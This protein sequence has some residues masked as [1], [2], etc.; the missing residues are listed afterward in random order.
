MRFDMISRNTL[1]G[2]GVNIIN[3][4]GEMRSVSDILLDLRSVIKSPIKNPKTYKHYLD[5]NS[6]YQVV[7][8]SPYEDADDL[9]I[10][11][12]CCRSGE[13]F[14]QFASIFFSN[15]ELLNG[16]VVQRFQEV[17]CS[18]IYK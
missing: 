9:L 6:F 12:R 7:A 2:L 4:Y 16:D 17:D 13:I 10:T 15:I 5:D 18:N 3:E 14:R 1:E 8:Y 11:Y